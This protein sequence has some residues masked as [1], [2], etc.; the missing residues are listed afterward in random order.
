MRPY[1]TEPQLGSETGGNLR[2]NPFLEMFSGR[3]SPGFPGKAMQP[4]HPQSTLTT[5]TT[6]IT[7]HFR[8]PP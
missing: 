5:H 3:A 6:H 8:Q 1:L 7:H 4:A 2:P